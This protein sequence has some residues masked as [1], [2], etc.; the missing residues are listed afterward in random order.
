M[1]GGRNHQDFLDDII[2]TIDKIE[3]FTT[4]MDFDSFSNDDK[5]IFAVIRGLEVIG[6][7]VKNISED[8]RK[9]NQDIPWSE[10]AGM[11]DKLIHAYF[12]VDVSVVWMTVAS[13][14]PDLKEKIE[15][16]RKLS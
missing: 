8:F 1:R 7:A 15:T 14:L 3:L 2:E 12:G 13:D 6:E 16:L 9:K 10:I 4:G 11:R 5:T